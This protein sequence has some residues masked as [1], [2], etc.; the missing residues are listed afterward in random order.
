LRQIQL[1][2]NQYFAGQIYIFDYGFMQ[3][4]YLIDSNVGSTDLLELFITEGLLPRPMAVGMA[5]IVA[6]IIDMFFGFVTYESPTQFFNT[7]FNDYTSYQ[8]TWPWLS[9]QD[10]FNV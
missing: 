3:I 5:V 4:S 10:A 7:P 2:L 1:L 9:Y 6:P 8:M